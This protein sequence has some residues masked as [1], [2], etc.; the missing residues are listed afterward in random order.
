MAV[1][2]SI[3][4][5]IVVLVVLAAAIP[6][7]VS[8]AQNIPASGPVAGPRVSAE[9]SCQTILAKA[10]STLEN[11]CSAVSRTTACY[12]NNN[13]QVEPAAAPTITFHTATRTPPLN[14][15]HPLSKPP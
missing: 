1:K 9:N 2:R 15:T 3:A 5:L 12:G 14:A 8:L 11:T 6:L 4:G 7:Q 13:V 10:L